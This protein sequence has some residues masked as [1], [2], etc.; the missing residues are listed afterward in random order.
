MTSLYVPTTFA[1]PFRRTRN[2]GLFFRLATEPSLHLWLGFGNIE[3]QMDV[4][5]EDGVIYT[6]GGI[7]KELPDLDVLLNGT[8]ERV[9][10]VLSGIP[11]EMI[12]DQV[13]SLPDVEG[14]DCHIGLAPL[15]QRQQ[16]EGP[17]RPIWFGLADFWVLAQQPRM[18]IDDA[19]ICSMILSCAG[20]DASRST[21]TLVSWTPDQ[22]HLLTASGQPTDLLCD[23]VPRYN[24]NYYLVWPR[25]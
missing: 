5:D 19:A 22:Q 23:R 6:G 21:P 11:E 9:D 10:F 1:E 8:A 7:V 3:A 4:V 25:W 18:S 15:D 20:G 13:T 16:L 14:A 12:I 2:A 24:Q 17:V